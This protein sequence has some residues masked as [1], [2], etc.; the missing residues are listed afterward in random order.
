MP[1]ITRE[2]QRLR[3]WRLVSLLGIAIALGVASI[4]ACG[5]SGTISAGAADAGDSGQAQGDANPTLGNEASVATDD[6]GDATTID[7]AAPEA[8][9]LDGDSGG[10][11]ADASDAAD[12]NLDAN[13]PPFPCGP[14]MECYE[15]T[16]FCGQVT[17]PKG[18]TFY[19][20]NEAPD[21]CAGDLSC[22]CLAGQGIVSPCSED[23]GG[24]TVVAT[25]P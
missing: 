3:A 24:I 16:Q 25:E 1:P 21:A 10:A 22:T 11:S 2:R 12:A 4:A 6:A 19:N 20:C 7:D 13:G 15:L 14:S 8:T 18:G 5:S 9:T 23:D 17:G